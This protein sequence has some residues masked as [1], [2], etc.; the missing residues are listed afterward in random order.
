MANRRG[1]PSTHVIISPSERATLEQ[2][3]AP[4][5][6]AARSGVARIVLGCTGDR[7]DVEI[8]RELRVHR[9]TVGEW[10]RRFQAARLDGLLDEPRPWAPRRI[11]EERVITDTLGND[12][13]RRHVVESR[14]AVV[15][16]TDRE[17]NPPWRASEHPRARDR[18]PALPGRHQRNAAT[19]RAA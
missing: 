19:V 10:R 1:R 14:R 7:T 11:H 16:R 2:C 18:H 15:C 13:P 4:P 3:V 12:A 6:H 17:T 8:A 9:L 5:L